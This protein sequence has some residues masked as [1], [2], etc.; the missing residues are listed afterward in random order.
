MCVLKGNL[1]QIDNS[2]FRFHV[3]TQT[4]NLVF[5]S[6]PVRKENRYYR[7][8]FVICLGNASMSYV[9]SFSKQWQLF[10][11]TQLDSASSTQSHDTFVEKTGIKPEELAGTVLDAGCGMGRFLEVVSRNSAVRVVGVDLST[12]V[13][14][15]RQNLATRSNVTIIQGDILDPNLFPT[16]SFDFIYSIGVIDHTP[17]PKQAFLNLARFLKPDGIIAIWVYKKWKG[18]L[19]SDQYRHLTCRLPW[20]MLLWMC[21]R[22]IKLYPLYKRFPSLVI[23]LPI[24]MHPDPEWRLLDTFDWYSPRYQFKFTVEEVVEWFKEANLRKIETLQIPVS[25]RG[26]R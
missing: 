24:S 18:S 6:D 20:R 22:A 25:V 1:L 4:I 2:L 8:C 14:A 7:R 10:N 17:N 11:R 16:E 5:Y 12:S 15:A 23:F 9:E 21:R 3:T 19:F 26:R 13:D